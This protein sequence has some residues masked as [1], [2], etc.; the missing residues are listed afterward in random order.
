MGSRD[1]IEIECSGR[2]EREA[3][4]GGLRVI[5]MSMAALDDDDDEGGDEDDEQGGRED[6][7][8]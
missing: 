2:D 6:E 8:V 5:V 4:L 3:L 1:A 7:A